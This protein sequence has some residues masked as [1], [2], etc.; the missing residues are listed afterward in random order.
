MLGRS[1]YRKKMRRSFEAWEGLVRGMGL[2][3][4]L[5]VDVPRYDAGGGISSTHLVQSV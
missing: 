1:K 4:T 3:G 2:Q 5:S